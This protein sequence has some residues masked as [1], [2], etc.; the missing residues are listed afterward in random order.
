MRK[1][2]TEDPMVHR[3]EQQALHTLSASTSRLPGPTLDDEQ[4]LP[5]VC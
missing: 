2:S 5:T 4:F 3:A 1:Y